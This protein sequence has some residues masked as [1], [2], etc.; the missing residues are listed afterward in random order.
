MKIYDVTII[1]GGLAGLTSAIDLS[2]SGFEVLVIEKDE[3]PKH[4]VCGEYVSNEVLPYLKRLGI[5]IEKTNADQIDRLT[6]SNRNGKSVNVKLPLGGFGMSRYALDY[7]LYEKAKS[8]GVKFKFDTVTDVEFE[9]EKFCIK[10]NRKELYSELA[11]GS[12]G[13]RST[14]DKKLERDFIQNKTP[15]IGIKAHYRSDDFPSGEVQLHNFEGGYCGLSKTETGAVNFC[16]L[17]HYDSFKKEGSVENFNTHI[18]TKN[19]E[20]KS[21]LDNS[22]IIFDKHIAISQVSFQNKSAVENHM[23]MAGDSA[24]LIHP[25]CGNG[26]AMAI[27]SAKLLSEEIK[28]FRKHK[29]RNQLEENYSKIWKQTFRKRLTFGSLFQRLLLQPK[30]TNIGMLAVSKSPYLLKKMIQQTHGK[31]IS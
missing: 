9:N 16:Y 5:D 20:L 1:G 31:P 19:P 11:I 14:L 23:L 22:E 7:L 24:G 26:M 28:A 21:F 25:L 13:K 3:Y 27:H 18:L 12:F 17:T 6:L 2:L 4:K 29:N 8:N 15:W 10:T 30:L